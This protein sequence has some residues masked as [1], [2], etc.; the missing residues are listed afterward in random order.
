VLQSHKGINVPGVRVRTSALTPK[1]ID[2]L[3]AGVAMGVDLVALSFV[4]SPDDINAARAVAAAAGAPDL[5]II[6][7]IEKP[8]ALA[9]T[10]AAA[11]LAA[12]AGAPDLPIIAKIEKPQ[13]VDQIE[14]IL[15]VADGIM[16]ARGD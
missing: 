13:A 1:D 2:D 15:Q 8:Q 10:N 12:A 3:R 4:Q 11:R 9:H 16:V 14:E 5:P 6:A 7:K